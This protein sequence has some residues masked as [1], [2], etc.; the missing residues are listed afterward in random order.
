MNCRPSAS[1]PWVS[2]TWASACWAQG[3]RSVMASARRAAASACASRW[4]CSQANAAMPCIC[5][6]SPAAGSAACARR[7]MPAASPALKRWY[8]PSL[9]DAR[10]R[11]CSRACSSCRSVA[12]AMSPSIQAA[13]ACTNRCSRSLACA[14]LAR[15]A[16][17]NGRALAG[18]SRDSANMCSAAQ[19]A[20]T[21]A[22]RSCAAAES[23][24]TARASQVMKPSMKS[25]SAARLAGSCKRTGFPRQSFIA[26]S[27]TAALPGRPC[28][29]AHISSRRWPIRR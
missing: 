3:S 6:T 5:G 1:R 11:G 24:L 27:R 4:H 29:A 8:W 23:T 17:M 28:P 10:S 25:F 20:C 7:S 18:P 22:L 15:A 2:I 13:T 19:L 16:S 9:I 26:V 12:R 21:I 14:A